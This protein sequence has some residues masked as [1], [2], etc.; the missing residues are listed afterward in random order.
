MAKNYWEV[1]PMKQPDQTACWST[2]MA[3]WTHAVSKVPN[4]REID[5]I[6]LF[7]HLTGSDGGLRFPNGFKQM[8]QDSTWGMTV[9]EFRGMKSKKDWQKACAKSPVMCGYWDTGVGGYHAVALHS[10]N[11]HSEKVFAMD[12][13]LGTHIRRDLSYY[14][15]NVTSTKV[16]LGYLA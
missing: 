9:E 10:Y 15:S 11:I 14:T 2:S 7:N 16:I 12:P 13:N 4:L 5:I 8:L 3:W 6:G 1:R